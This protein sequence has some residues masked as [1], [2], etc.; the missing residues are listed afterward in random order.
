MTLSLLVYSIAQRR[1]RI[2]LEKMDETIPNKINKPIKNSTARWLFFLLN[3]INIVNFKLGIAGKKIIENFDH[4][5][6]KKIINGLDFLKTKIIK[7]FG[8]RVFDIYTRY[9][10]EVVFV[11]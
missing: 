8:D 9:K 2:N 1:A 7:L 6:G 5:V 11:T 4:V 3:G 10:T